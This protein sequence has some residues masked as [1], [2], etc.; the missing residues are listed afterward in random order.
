MLLYR[1]GW[2]CVGLQGP[3]Q[4]HKCSS[5]AVCLVI[6]GAPVCTCPTCPEHYKPVCGSDGVSYANECKLQA[7]N[8]DKK[9]SITVKQ[10]GLCSNGTF[11]TPLLLLA[12][13]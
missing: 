13:K 4:H 8:C 3:C 10:Q 7:E 9:T 11:C 12:L 6:G 1:S 5:G 2:L